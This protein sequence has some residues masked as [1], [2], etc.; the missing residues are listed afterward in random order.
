MLEEERKKQQ[1]LQQELTHYK[2]QVQVGDRII[3]Q[4]KG[5]LNQLRTENSQTKQKLQAKDKQIQE[6][7]EQLITMTNLIGQDLTSQIEFPPKGQF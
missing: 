4:L 5:E 2:N 6:L 1:P 3:Q 7:T